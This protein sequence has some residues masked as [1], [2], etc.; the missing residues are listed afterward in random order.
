MN[1]EAAKKLLDRL[2]QERHNHASDRDKS[3]TAACLAQARY[4]VTNEHYQDMR[5]A[6]EADAEAEQHEPQ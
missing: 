3:Q 2:D 4:Q 1:K 5:A 6:I